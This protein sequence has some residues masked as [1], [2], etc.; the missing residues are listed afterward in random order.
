[1]GSA[2][3]KENVSPN[4]EE[5]VI[6]LLGASGSGKTTLVNFVANFFEGIKTP[7]EEKVLVAPP[8]LKTKEISAYTFPSST[9]GGFNLFF[10]TYGPVK[11][12]DNFIRFSRGKR[13]NTQSPGM[14]GG[15][16]FALFGLNDF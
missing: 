7:D 14:N 16:L 5:N 8:S 10:T 9:P 13:I 2:F 12:K 3:N 15:R 11:C 6:L 4:M 1:M